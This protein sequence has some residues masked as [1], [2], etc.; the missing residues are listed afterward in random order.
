[1][2]TTKKRVYVGLSG[3]VDSSVSLA[4]LKDKGYDVTGVF[5][6]VW[7][8][9]FLECTWKEDRRDAMR[10]C[11]RLEVPFKEYD[12]E[13]EY[14]AHVVDYMIEEYR[15]GRTPNPDIMCN[16]WVKFDAFL[17]QA[18]EEG[19]DY[20]ATGHYARVREVESYEL[21]AGVDEK[22]DQSYFLWTLGQHELPH[23]LFPIG[24][25]KKTEVRDYAHKY[26]LITAEKKD[27]QGLCFMGQVDM[28]EFLKRYIHTEEGEVVNTEGEII[29][30]HEG[31]MLYTTGQRHGFTITQKG[32][33]DKPYYVYDRDIE[34]NTIT[35]TNN[36][37]ETGEL[38]AARG[39][40][41][42]SEHW[43][44]GQEPDL[45]IT[46]GARIRYRQPLESCKVVRGSEGYEVHFDEPQKAVSSGQSV[47]IYRGEIVV[48]GGIVN[49]LR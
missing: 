11:A 7:H 46:Y 28:R 1:M 29:G 22:K 34:A 40:L 39:V 23:T 21:L 5:I 20:I 13:E 4:F 42:E 8:P 37:T 35:V 33:D 47:V 26:N 32:T 27:S 12:F 49:A 10:V 44:S 6:K 25:L 16:K 15:K 31:A 45:S 3:G 30:R 19:A 14:K 17:N 18:L 2:N 41:L 9:D 48:G 24:H 43:V 36:P 38:Y